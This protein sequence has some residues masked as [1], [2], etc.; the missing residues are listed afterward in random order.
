MNPTVCIIILNWNNYHDTVSCIQSLRQM[1]FFDYQVVVVDN[2][3]S[4]ESVEMLESIDNIHFIKNEKNLGF[5]G[6]NNVAMKYAIEQNFDYVWLLNSDATVKPDCLERMV[7]AVQNASEVGLASPVIY[8]Q[9]RPDEIQHCG[10]RLNSAFDGVDEAADIHTAQKWQEADSGNVILWGTA[11][12]ISTKLIREI[13]YL[14]EQLFAY[15]EDTDYSLRSSKA[16]FKNVTVFD[17]RIWHQSTD[18]LRKAHFY[19]YTVRNVGLMW[20]KYVSGIKFIKICW[21]NLNRTAK[22]LKLMNQ[23][24]HLEMACKLGLWDGWVGKGGAFYPRRKLPLI[25]R[26]L[27]RILLKA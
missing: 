7:L 24:P 4:N 2:G 18:G 9:H 12:L 1:S 15:S 10:T 25:P 8:H 16:G 14:D 17:A 21:W 19:Y 11:L 23:H 5:A 26:V 20:R 6:G 27:F 13:G 3:S 22:Q